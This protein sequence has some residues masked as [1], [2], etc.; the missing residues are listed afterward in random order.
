MRRSAQINMEQRAVQNLRDAGLERVSGDIIFGLPGQTM[1]EWQSDVNALLDLNLDSITTYDCLYRG[2]GRPM[3]RAIV[4][5]HIP[6]KEVYGEMYDYVYSALTTNGYHAPYGSLNFS[7]RSNETG[8]S[9]YFENRL[10][11]GLPYL[12]LGNYATTLV[13]RFWFFA[14]YSVDGWIHSLRQDKTTNNE[15][16]SQID[17]LAAWPVYQ[18][19]S[20]SVEERMAKYLLLS[21]SFGHLDGNKFREAFPGWDLQT[22]FGQSL[23]VL[24]NQ[25]KWMKH[26]PT[27]D[28]YFLTE[29]NFCHMSE[30]RALFYTERCLSWFEHSLQMSLKDSESL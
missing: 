21:L 14:P 19:Y 29:G 22:A 4:R 3:S 27:A 17:L 11:G 9:S 12:G 6:S 30:I 13:D 24:V 1:Q 2:K 25:R 7:K 26:D 5:D 28:R 10:L 8:T 23:E 16:P 15:G 18:G 20:L